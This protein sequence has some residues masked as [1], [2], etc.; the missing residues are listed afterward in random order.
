MSTDKEEEPKANNQQ[1]TEAFPIIVNGLEPGS[2]APEKYS[3]RIVAKTV[4]KI[5]QGLALANENPPNTDAHL[6]AVWS[7]FYKDQPFLDAASEWTESSPTTLYTSPSTDQ[8]HKS[9]MI[10]DLL[11]LEK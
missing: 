4:L 9:Y 3:N 7:Y 5:W 11:E 10:K 6:F 1:K 2:L 8:G